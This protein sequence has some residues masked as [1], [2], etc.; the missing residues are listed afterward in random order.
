MMLALLPPGCSKNNGPKIVGNWKT[1][2]IDNTDRR[3]INTIIN[4]NKEGVVLKTT[5]VI[6]NED[7][8]RTNKIAGKYKYVSDNNNISITWNDGKSETTS[9]IF[10]GENKML[11]GKDEMEKVP[12]DR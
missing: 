1:T 4:F 7:L 2:S 10:P 6:I 3:I 12:S 8:S 11:L 9:V 5:E